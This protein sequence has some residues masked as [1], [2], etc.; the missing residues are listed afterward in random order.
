MSFQT[1]PGA[2]EPARSAP[3]KQRRSGFAVSASVNLRTAQVSSGLVPIAL[4][5]LLLTSPTLALRS[6][7]TGKG[8]HTASWTRRDQ[9]AGQSG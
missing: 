3:G 9:A 2:A 6:I 5:V 4:L 7:C 1:D 8:A